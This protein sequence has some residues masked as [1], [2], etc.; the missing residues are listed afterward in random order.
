MLTNQPSRTSI[1]YK[2]VLWSALSTGGPTLIGLLVFVV[3][4]R[5]L[6]PADFGLVAMAASIGMIVA[7]FVPAGFGDALVQRREI[8]PVHIDSVF[9]ACSGIGLMLYI[10]I[11]ALGP[12]VANWMHHQELSYLVPIL[13]VRVIFDAAAIVPLSI[14]KRSLAF[15]NLAVRTIVSTGVAGCAAL[16][17]AL[18]GFGFWA[19]VA[20]S[21][22]GSCIG[23]VGAFWAANWRPTWRFS[24]QAFRE[25]AAYGGYASLTQTLTML[26]QQG[27]QAIV[28]FSLGIAPLGL[29]TFSRRILSVLNDLITGTLATVA[30]PIMSTLQT[31]RAA[32]R[33]G[34]L[35]ASFISSAIGFPVFIGLAVISGDLVPVIFGKHW[36]AAIPTVQLLCLLGLLLAVGILQA[37]LI[38]SQ[39]HIKWWMKYQIVSIVTYLIVILTCARFG[40]EIMVAAVVIRSYLLVIFPYAK[41]IFIL[42]TSIRSYLSEFIPPLAASI[43]MAGVLG[44]RHYLLPVESAAVSIGI[45]V[46]TGVAI[47]V[48]FLALLGKNRFG[49]LARLVGSVFRH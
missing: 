6:K 30:L 40:I 14:I 45:D 49:I 31:E 18:A 41:T 37:S 44:G 23:M 2:G 29:Y 24:Q 46:P 20:S 36:V 3:T 48:S 39:G 4:G 38:K 17:F 43:I 42:E 32:L 1:A 22:I 11:A 21:I 12:Y 35:L 5:L 10:L 26:N 9:W 16:G 8:T 27:E 15:R 47:Y 7:C 13:S 28:G 19:L 25:L 34:F 33:R